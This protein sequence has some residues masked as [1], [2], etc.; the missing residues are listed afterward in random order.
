MSRRN[1]ECLTVLHLASMISGCCRIKRWYVD[2]FKSCNIF[3]CSPAFLTFLLLVQSLSN[4]GVFFVV[5]FFSCR[6]CIFL[7]FLSERSKPWKADLEKNLLIPKWGWWDQ[8]FICCT[9]PYVQHLGS[10]ATQE[11][12]FPPPFDPVTVEP[13]IVCRVAVVTRGPAL[14]WCSR[15][16]VQVALGLACCGFFSPII[17][18]ILM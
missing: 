14:Y 7:V 16:G 8:V 1:G 5:F 3:Y 6:M 11:G 18:Q 2:R 10:G 15:V 17:S 13:V 12:I 9:L 4:S